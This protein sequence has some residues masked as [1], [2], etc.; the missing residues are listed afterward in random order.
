MKQGKKKTYNEQLIHL[1]CPEK[2]SRMKW[3][4]DWKGKEKKKRSQIDRKELQLT[5][6]ELS[7]EFNSIQLTQQERAETEP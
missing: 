3:S 5:Q 4:L 1:T 2:S 7:M 6:Y